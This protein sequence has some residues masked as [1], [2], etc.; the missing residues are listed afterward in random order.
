MEQHP[1]DFTTLADK[2]VYGTLADLITPNY[3][4]DVNDLEQKRCEV[5]KEA[6]RIDK[7]GKKLDT[8]W[9]KLKM[10]LSTQETWRRSTSPS[11]NNKWK[12]AVI[13]S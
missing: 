8:T 11:S 6:K 2:I 10:R 9:Q 13:R 7:M 1:E 5:L 4:K 12:T 3:L